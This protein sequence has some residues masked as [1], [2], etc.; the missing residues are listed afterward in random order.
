[1]N[2]KLYNLQF[3]IGV[4]FCII[5][6]IVLITSFYYR[7]A[8]GN[9]QATGQPVLPVNLFSGAGLLSFGSIMLISFFIYFKKENTE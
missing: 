2:S 6:S 7:S 5:G 1:M 9:I 3:V 8:N 4:F